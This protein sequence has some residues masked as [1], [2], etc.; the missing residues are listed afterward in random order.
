MRQTVRAPRLLRA[1][2]GILAGPM[3]RVNGADDDATGAGAFQVADPFD[4]SAESPSHRRREGG[5]KVAFEP[6]RPQLKSRD[7]P[8]G[9]PGRFPHVAEPLAACM[10]INETRGSTTRAAPQHR[11][12]NKGRSAGW[13]VTRR[14]ASR[15]ETP[16]VRAARA[17][18]PKPQVVIFGGLVETGALFGSGRV[19]DMGRCPNERA[20]AQGS[21]RRG[22]P[23]PFFLDPASAARATATRLQGRGRRRESAEAE[24]VR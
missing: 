18:M 2:V 7:V 11:D 6:L 8:D 9:S 17:W 12:P 22:D 4:R 10:G 1:G 23:T 19:G 15:G 20:P 3:D 24:L 13:L 21:G 5:R 14:Q 16:R